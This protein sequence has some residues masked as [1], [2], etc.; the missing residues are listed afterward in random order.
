MFPKPQSC[1]FSDCISTA[2]SYMH[3]SFDYAD[4]GGALNDRI[5]KRF[6]FHAETWFKLAATA[7]I[8]G[9]VYTTVGYRNDLRGKI[10]IEVIHLGVDGQGCDEWLHCPIPPYPADVA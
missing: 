9:V 10:A 1:D 4:R 8:K 7:R 3:K 2:N 5:S 6:A